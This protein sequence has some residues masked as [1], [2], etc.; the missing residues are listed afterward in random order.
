MEDHHVDRPGVDVRQ[1]MKL[2]G[3]NRSFGLISDE[4]R[5]HHPGSPAIGSRL[6][7]IARLGHTVPKASPPGRP[8]LRLADLVVTARGAAPDPIPNSAEK[9]LCAD[10]TASQD[11]G[12]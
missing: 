3:T 11:V 12:E 5:I 7:G 1:R 6:E 8:R 9:T 2:T 10:G 4:P